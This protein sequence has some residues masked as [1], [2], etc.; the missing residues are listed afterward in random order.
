MKILILYIVSI[1]LW[2][3]ADGF[4]DDGH[5]KTGHLLRA[6]SFGVLLVV[7]YFYVSGIGWC[8]A[9]Y[10]CLHVSLF[11]IIYNI[12]RKLPVTYH[13]T[14]NYWDIIMNLFNPPAWAELFGRVVILFTGVMMAIQNL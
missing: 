1:V 6:L 10:I 4:R 9:S 11:D 12:K 3:L 14:T 7:P 2:S 5:K 8:L 13:G